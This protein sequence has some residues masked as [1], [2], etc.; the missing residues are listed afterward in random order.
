LKEDDDMVLASGDDLS[1]D[2][3]SDP[4]RQSEH[5]WDKSIK[6]LIGIALLIVFAVVLARMNPAAHETSSV[7]AW[8]TSQ[9]IGSAAR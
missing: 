1:G 4:A 9:T 3:K 7:P 6:T 5:G 2:T 8:T